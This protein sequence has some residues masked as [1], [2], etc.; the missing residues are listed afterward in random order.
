M[1]HA[2]DYTAKRNDGLSAKADELFYSTGL[3]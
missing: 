1:R 3:L 2:R